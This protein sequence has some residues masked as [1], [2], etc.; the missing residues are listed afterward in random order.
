MRL[1]QTRIYADLAQLQKYPYFAGKIIDTEKVE[2]AF[3]CKNFACSLPIL[4]LSDFQKELRVR[5]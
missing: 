4:S 1:L 3:V 5:T 2:Y